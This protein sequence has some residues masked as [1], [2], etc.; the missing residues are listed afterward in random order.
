MAVTNVSFS[1][2]GEPVELPPENHE[3]LVA[4]VVQQGSQLLLTGTASKDISRQETSGTVVR[5]TWQHHSVL[6]DKPS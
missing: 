1:Q 3:L 4:L 6:W 5:P 2:S